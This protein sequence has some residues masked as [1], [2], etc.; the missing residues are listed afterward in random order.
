LGTCCGKSRG[1]HLPFRARC[2]R[3]CGSILRLRDDQPG[4]GP[5]LVIAHVPGGKATLDQA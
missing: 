2:R 5:L 3:R 4:E 1:Q